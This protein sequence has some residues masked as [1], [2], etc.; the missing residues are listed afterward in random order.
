[1]FSYGSGLIAS[2]FMITVD[3]KHE[4]F[5]KMKNLMEFKTRLDSRIQLTPMEYEKLMEEREGKYGKKDYETDERDVDLLFHSTYY[6]Y[7]VDAKWRRYY[8]IKYGLHFK[9]IASV[10]DSK[11]EQRLLSL[12]SQITK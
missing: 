1:M 7:S 4:Y 8:K 12:Q 11:S 3:S 2:M 6:L 9:S 5:Q 10:K